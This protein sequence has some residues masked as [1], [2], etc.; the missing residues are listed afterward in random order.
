MVREILQ[1]ICMMMFL[2]SFLLIE[3][4]PLLT[5]ILVLVFGGLMLLFEKGI[6]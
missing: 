4:S 1:S 5:L 6:L 3:V 2:F